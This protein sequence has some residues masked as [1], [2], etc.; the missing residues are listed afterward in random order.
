[1]NIRYF[2]DT[3]G[4]TKRSITIP[5]S[6]VVSTMYA[7]TVTNV[8]TITVKGDVRWVRIPNTSPAIN[9]VADDEHTL[10]SAAERKLSFFIPS[11]TKSIVLRGLQVITQAAKDLEENKSGKAQMLND[12]PIISVEKGTVKKVIKSCIGYIANITI[13]ITSIATP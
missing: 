12:A 1:M 10:C 3:K 11:H 7:S 6:G 4:N 13:P 8:V 5:V 9:A 2:T